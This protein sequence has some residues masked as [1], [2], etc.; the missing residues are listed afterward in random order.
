MY[1][2]NMGFDQGMLFIF[3]EEGFHSFWMKNMIISLDFIWLDK[4]KRIVHFEQDV[5]PCKQEPCPTYTSKVPALFVLELIAGSV[6]K[7][8]LK[9]FDRLDFIL[10]NIQ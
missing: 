5:L 3:D 7:R 2:K 1:R 4:E 9:M 10:P 6:E 8:K